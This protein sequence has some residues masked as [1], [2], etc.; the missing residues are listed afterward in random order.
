MVQKLIVGL[1]GGFGAGKSSVAQ[2]FKNLGADVID[3]DKIAHDAMKKGSPVFDLIAQ[4]FEEALHPSG[5]K[6]DR[7]QVAEIVFADPGKRKELE[8]IIHPYVYERIKEKIEASMSRVVLVE[9]PLLFETGFEK[10]C[11]KVL[12]VTCNNTIKLKRLKKDGFP[13]QEV[14]ARERAQ[15]AESLKAR[16]ADFIIDNSKSIYQTQREIERL[17]SKFVSLNKSTT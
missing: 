17:W 6:M 11:D 15:M 4:L 12:T 7:E 14:R 13:P 10:L 3:A 5:K 2:R 8:K 1:T 9:V 16:K